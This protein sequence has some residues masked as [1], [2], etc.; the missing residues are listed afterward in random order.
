MTLKLLDL[1]P[2]TIFARSFA[3]AHSHHCHFNGY[4]G[5]LT[6]VLVEES[7]WNKQTNKGHTG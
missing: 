3:S 7:G 5:A 1:Q 2:C 6:S 4:F